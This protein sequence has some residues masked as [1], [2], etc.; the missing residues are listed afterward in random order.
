MRKNINLDISADHY[1]TFIVYATGTFVEQI[2]TGKLPKTEES[3]KMIRDM[4]FGSLITT[5]PG[6]SIEGIIRDFDKKL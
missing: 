3:Y 2:I 4:V 6:I 1:R 5:V